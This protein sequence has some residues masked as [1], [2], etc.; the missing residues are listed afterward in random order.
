MESANEPTPMTYL[1]VFIALMLLLVLTT[2]LGFVDL[3]KY[4][5]GHFWSILVALVIALAKG[6][7][8][9]LFFMHLK[10]GPKPV[11]A[12]ALAGFFWLG[13]LLVL[14]FADYATRN[15]PP[16]LNYKGEPRYLVSQK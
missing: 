3:D 11:I 7:L 16:D 8:I 14:T 1:K 6:L 9:L 2:G 4:L 5:H 15:H 10:F 13:I 12:F